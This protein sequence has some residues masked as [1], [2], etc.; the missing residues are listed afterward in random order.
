MQCFNWTHFWPTAMELNH[1]VHCTNI[2]NW[3]QRIYQQICHC[4]R[5]CNVIWWNLINLCNQ[6]FNKSGAFSITLLSLIGRSEKKSMLMNDVNEEVGVLIDWKWITSKTF[7]S[8]NNVY[9]YHDLERY[10]FPGRFNVHRFRFQRTA[11]WR[12]TISS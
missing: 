11:H 6:C 10:H 5:I 8:H 4:F 3:Y 9:I 1:C 12:S 2:Y 7:T